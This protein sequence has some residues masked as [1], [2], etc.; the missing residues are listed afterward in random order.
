MRVRIPVRRA[1]PA[2]R[3]PPSPWRRASSPAQPADHGAQSAR[4]KNVYDAHCVECHG[5]GGNGDGPAAAL[6]H[7]AAARLHV[8]QVQDPI[9]RDRQRADRRRP[10]PIGAPTACTARD[11]GLGRILSDSDIRDVVEYIKTM[12][13]AL[14]AAIAEGR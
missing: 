11:A 4:G 9:D 10:D 14:R 13:P 2:A 1:R 12:S 5:A 8:R 7:A 6:L 3:A